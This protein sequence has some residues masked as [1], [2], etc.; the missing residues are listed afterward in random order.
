MEHLEDVFRLKSTS[1]EQI[2][3]VADKGSELNACLREAATLCIGTRCN[4]S[5]WFNMQQ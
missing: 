3:I 4:V 1:I 2:E 5:L